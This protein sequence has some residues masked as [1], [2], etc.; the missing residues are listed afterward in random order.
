MSAAEGNEGPDKV[1]L[2]AVSPSM[3]EAGLRELAD[4]VGRLPPAEI[5]AAVY[6]AMEYERL[7]AL[8]KLSGL[9]EKALEIRQG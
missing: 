6:L 1:Q 4:V 5:V 7:F 2:V 3:R 8:G 9:G